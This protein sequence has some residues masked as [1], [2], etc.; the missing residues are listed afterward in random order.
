M[1]K[2]ENLKEETDYV[3]KLGLQTLNRR[4]AI[5]YIEIAKE[6][7]KDFEL[8]ETQKIILEKIFDKIKCNSP[9]KAFNLIID[10]FQYI[11][12]SFSIKDILNLTSICSKIEDFVIEKYKIPIN[13]TFE[14]KIENRIS[15][16][17]IDLD[18]NKKIFHDNVNN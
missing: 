5:A 9:N 10:M 7:N 4:Q 14:T 2:L 11:E 3:Y 6:S 16:I 12:T 18:R 13:G 15:I 8:V 17:E 1:N